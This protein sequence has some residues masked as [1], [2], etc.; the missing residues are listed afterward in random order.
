MEWKVEDIPSCDR[1]YRAV[2]VVFWQN[3]EPDEIPPGAWKV[4]GDGCSVD[5]ERYSTPQEALNRR[6]DP[7]MNV[8]L[9]VLASQIRDIEGLDVQ[10][11]PSP[12]NRAHSDIVGDLKAGD[13]KARVLLSRKAS[14]AIDA[15]LRELGDE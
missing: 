14:F 10:H 6:K 3:A 7:K 1:V 5:W 11:R 4:V 12:D 15:A 13:P 8:I 9:E 2:H